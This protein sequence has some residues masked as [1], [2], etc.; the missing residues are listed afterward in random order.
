MTRALGLDLS[1]TSSGVACADGTLHVV[2]P[3]K[4]KDARRLSIILDQ[5][6]PLMARGRPELAV[7]EGAAGVQFASTA[8]LLGELRGAVKL[9]LFQRD[10]PM[11]EVPPKS[12]KKWATGNGN[13]S[14]D[15]MVV[16]A[17]D[18]GARIGRDEHDKADAFWLR[19]VG[20]AFGRH[21]AEQGT[22]MSD[23]A[24]LAWLKGGER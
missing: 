2:T 9:R 3:G 22:G 19:R 10:L 12:L 17:Q 16:A 23:A 14:K 7:I 4:A 8:L 6:E 5:L 18:A 1:A 20:E 21:V 13:A 24:L 11:V 15:E